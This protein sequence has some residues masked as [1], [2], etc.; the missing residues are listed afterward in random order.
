MGR[1]PIENCIKECLG[2][3]ME[4]KGRLRRPQQGEEGG[5]A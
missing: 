2:P 3:F 4:S 5:Y 1:E